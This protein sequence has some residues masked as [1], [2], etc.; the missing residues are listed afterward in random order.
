MEESVGA[1]NK[2]DYLIKEQPHRE[3]SVSI[4]ERAA[5]KFKGP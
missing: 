5:A 3:P 2:A 4:I 1:T